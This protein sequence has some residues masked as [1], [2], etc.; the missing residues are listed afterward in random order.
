MERKL[1]TILA[2]DVAGYSRLMG[3]D[4][5]ATLHTLRAYRAVIDGLI[6]G[7]RGRVF[8]SAGDS[9]IA[10]FASPVEAVRCAAAIQRDVETRNAALP[11]DRRM[12]F[13][14]GVNLGDVMV[15]GD[16]LLGDGVNVA[17]RL[18]ELAE[19]GGVYISGA[20][21]EQVKG[22]LDLGFDDLGEQDVKNIAQP[23]PTYRVAIGP[24]VSSRMRRLARVGS[25]KHRGLAAGAVLVLLAAAI[26]VGLWLEPWPTTTDIEI[27]VGDSGA[28]KLPDKPSIAVLPFTN[29]SGD[30]AQDYFS[31]GIT[32][33]IITALSRFTDLF[34]IARNSVFTYK[35][36]PVKVQQVSRELG[37]RYVLEG[38][39]QK[40]GDRVRIHAQ[41]IDAT[42]G[43]HLWAER[44]EGDLADVFAL[45]DELTQKIVTPLAVEMSA[46]EVKRVLQ[47]D[48]DNLAAYDYVLRGYRQMR[49]H[50]KESN[51][52]ARELFETAIELDPNYARAYTRMAFT[53][54]ND[55][56][57]GWSEDPE[58]SRMVALELAEKAV[59]LDD[60]FA[61]A[62]TALGDVY[63]WTK[64]Y[65]R[66]VAEMERAIALNPNDADGYEGLGDVLTWVGR[67]DEAIG[68]L[69][70]A[71]RLNPNY[72]F[73]YLWG[74]AHAYFVAERYEEA[75]EILKQLRTRNP[76]FGPA[77][78]YLAASYSLLDRMEE[79]RAEMVE[80]V[81]Y[82]PEWSYA[83]E[84]E[85]LPYKN[86]ADLERMLNALQKLGFK[87]CWPEGARIVAGPGTMRPGNGCCGS[88]PPSGWC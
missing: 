51:A 70:R 22:K 3:A 30:E 81:K 50:T 35:G 83:H 56:R 47:K 15:E 85:F 62:H 39:V 58:R 24:G 42:T 5:E 75:I 25:T 6:A 59:A 10:E 74:L 86:S 88:A 76:N 19:P 87:E 82:F 20:V 1:A 48:T 17:A 38:S 53:H 65:D 7:H 28:L 55:F 52:Q 16:N 11:E 32:E 9:V 77:Y 18:E 45:Q 37:V 29:L 71:M 40:S 31:D 63:L 12:R 84:R 54:L 23:V 66:A 21:F 8:G 60:T 26:G 61:D 78:L 44:F 79:A 13:R 68:Y 73:F 41:L 49:L 43:H 4:E 64:Q 57:L 46:A 69:K 72:P 2:A 14:I 27:A 34:V 36:R 67:P 33:D 80:V